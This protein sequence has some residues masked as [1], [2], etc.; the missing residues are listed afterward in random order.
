MAPLPPNST[1]R[2]WLDYS[3]DNGSHSMLCR[4]ADGVLDS[5]A[6]DSID[7]FLTAIVGTICEITITAFRV[8]QLGSNISTLLTWPHAA[9]YGAVPQALINAPSFFDFVGRTHLG[10]RARVF[11]Y[12]CSSVSQAD[13]RYQPGEDADLDAARAVLVAAADT[14]LAIDGEHPVWHP[15][16]NTGLNSYYQRKA[17][18]T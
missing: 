3:T 7:A 8:A 17:R 11:L 2:Y 5:E 12:A 16:I 18:I 9:T 6:A 1:K 4:V 10:R 13:Y 14:F 15:Y